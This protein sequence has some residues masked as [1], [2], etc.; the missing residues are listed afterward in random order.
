MK[1]V[2]AGEDL[3]G[4]ILSVAEAL[5]YADGVRSVGVDRI[6]AEAGIAK[7]T[8]YRYFQTK[9]DLV[10]AYLTA[11]HLRVIAS[12]RELVDQAPPTPEDRVGALF[13]S[14]GNRALRR[15]FRGCP[16]LLVLSEYPES[17]RVRELAMR[18]KR[19]VRQLFIDIVR[20]VDTP[21]GDVGTLFTL[22]YEGA[23][24]MSSVEGGAQ[25]FTVALR[26]VE[27]ILR[28]C[29]AQAHEPREGSPA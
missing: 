27:Y 1:T 28:A 2:D 20:D 9:D 16:L 21:L 24:V 10:V 8:L 6:A 18:H 13:L 7:A 3:R 22:I 26:N 14:L 19:A 12:L 5:F 17:P 15:D 29:G 11:F 4:H 25:S 23:S